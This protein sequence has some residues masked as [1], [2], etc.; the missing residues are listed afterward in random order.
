L[1]RPGVHEGYL[2]TEPRFGT[3]LE[4][5]AVDILPRASPMK[6]IRHS[7][8]LWFLMTLVMGFPLRA[9]AQDRAVQGTRLADA[10]AKRYSDIHAMRLRFVQTASSAFMDSDERFSGELVFTETAYRVRTSNQT[11]VTDGTTTW[12]HNKAEGQ[13][14][15]NDFVE[16]ETSFS[17]TSF[18]R[19]FSKD[20]SATWEGKDTLSGAGHDRLRLL[21]LDDFASF[22]QVDLW[23]R[24]SNGLVT[25]LVALDLN[26][27]R[28]TF[29][30]SDL[31]VNPA[32][33]AD[34]F[35]FVLPSGV[36]VVDL[37]ENDE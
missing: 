29:D 35:Q 32:L 25:R 6:S 3:P 37:R 20:Y 17:L 5:R 31:E 8:L 15:I 22:R 11:I 4:G 2:E 13:V 34:L 27:V 28:M 16:D 12:I 9:D 26:D 10:L 24:A 36:E 18:L 1:K 14:L 7:L 23:I 19:S 30:L 21:P 33:P